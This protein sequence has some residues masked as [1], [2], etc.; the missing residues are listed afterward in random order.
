MFDSAPQQAA[1]EHVH[2]RL[3]AITERIDTLNASQ[4]EPSAALD[5]IK[6]EIG[7]L[8]QRNRREAAAGAGPN[9]DHLESQI[10]DL[11]TQLE[12]VA[13][14]QDESQALA[15][16]EA[17]VAH[18]ASEL[19]QTKPRAGALHQVE[20]SLDRLQALLA[21]TAQESIARARAEARKA[22]NEL[23]EVVAGNEIDSGLIRGLMR[24]LDS[25]RK[26]PAATRRSEHA[27]A[28]RIR[29]PDDV[30][31]RRPPEPARNRGHQPSRPE[32][33]RPR[34]PTSRYRPAQRDCR[35]TA[36]GG[37]ELS[38]GLRFIRAIA[39]VRELSPRFR[40]RRK[41][42]TA[43]PT[44]SPPHGAPPRPSP[45]RPPASRPP[46]PTVVRPRRTDRR[47][48]NASPAPSPG[49]AR[50][51]A[52]ASG[53]CCL[54]PRRSC[55]PSARCR[56][57][58]S[59]RSAISNTELHRRKRTS[60]TRGSRRAVPRDRRRPPTPPL[61]CR[62]VTEQ[63][64]SCRPPRTPDATS[65]L[66]SR[67]ALRQPL[68][69][70]TARARR[71]RLRRGARRGN[72]R[73][74]AGADAQTRPINASDAGQVMLASTGGDAP[75]TAIRSRQPPR[76][77][78]SSLA[79]PSDGDPAAAFEI[80]TRYAEGIARRQEPRQGG[81]VVRQGGGGRRRRRPVPPRQP[82]RARPGRRQ[83]PD[84][85]RSTGTSAPPTRATSTPCTI[86]P[87]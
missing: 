10:R 25:L 72:G 15:D 55:S 32:P 86:S 80:A 21:D 18:L 53:R 22:V 50:R 19:E 39:A 45:T 31:G 64:P 69:R 74:R 56:S 43:A 77:A 11:A 47:R 9:T 70:C 5:A 17:Q 20:E 58:A 85:A 76:L 36:A 37:Q 3:Q 68:R 26:P 81:G 73:K 67:K 4:R 59:F 46:P 40:P 48:P 7:A 66:P 87:S 79:R 38:A 42:P 28:T 12:T 8:R 2:E 61:P 35:H 62:Q 71:Q 84:R 63:A 6:S 34:R 65:P 49:S 27:R 29:Q 30:P 60:S 82:L 14:S 24:D 57:T 52:A 54:P 51:S 83:G 41:P 16:L 13:S 1:I 75:A 78:R 33:L 44:S 23:S